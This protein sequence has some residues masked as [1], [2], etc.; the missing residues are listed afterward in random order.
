MDVDGDAVGVRLD[1]HEVQGL[2]DALT[3]HLVASAK[4]VRS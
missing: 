3:C 2:R 1:R 4:P